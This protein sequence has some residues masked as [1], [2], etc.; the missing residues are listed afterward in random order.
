MHRQNCYSISHFE[1]K[2]IDTHYW[3]N[4]KFCPINDWTEFLT[5]NIFCYRFC[6][7]DY[8][9][10]RAEEVKKYVV[11]DSYLGVPEVSFGSCLLFLLMSL[12][13]DNFLVH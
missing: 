9:P 5:S 10:L 7:V 3:S 6:T 1:F 11:G 4:I 8:E 13:A 12:N 2:S